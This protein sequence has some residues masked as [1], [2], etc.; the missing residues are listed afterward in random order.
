MVECFKFLILS[1]IIIYL[2]YSFMRIWFINFK[3]LRIEFNVF[4]FFY[5]FKNG[6]WVFGYD[7][8]GVELDFLGM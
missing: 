6:L 2:C 7:G 8:N 1:F 5:S 4:G 3:G